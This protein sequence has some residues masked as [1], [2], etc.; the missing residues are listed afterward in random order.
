MPY[1]KSIQLL[2]LFVYHLI[3]GKPCWA[4][5]FIVITS[6]VCKIHVKVSLQC[7][8]LLRVTRYGQWCIDR[9]LWRSCHLVT[10][11]G[12]SGWIRDLCTVVITHND[13]CTCIAL[14]EWDGPVVCVNATENIE[15]FQS[16][17]YHFMAT[18]TSV[19]VSVKQH[20][21]GKVT[22]CTFSVDFKEIKTI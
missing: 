10:K 11:E 18:Q 21:H 22:R 4:L 5:V 9:Y 1:I 12:V 17:F 7:R 13:L 6:G 14:T 15:N 19:I 2:T 8:G 20:E 16:K 3:N